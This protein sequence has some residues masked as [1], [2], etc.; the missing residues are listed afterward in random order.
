[1]MGVSET[2]QDQDNSARVHDLSRG[3][4][5]ILDLHMLLGAPTDAL[6]L[7]DESRQ[8]IANREWCPS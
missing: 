6:R 5:K 8:S 4:V 7:F 3:T 2:K 1:M